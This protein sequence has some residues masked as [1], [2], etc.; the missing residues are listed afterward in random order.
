MVV[1]ITSLFLSYA[2]VQCQVVGMGGLLYVLFRNP[3]PFRV[4]PRSSFHTAGG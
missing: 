1:P 4:G 2:I 3:G